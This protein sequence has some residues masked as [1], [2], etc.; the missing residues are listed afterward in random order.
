MNCLRTKITFVI[1]AM[2]LGRDGK[3]LFERL[4][5]GDGL[6]CLDAGCGGGVTLETQR[7]NHYVSTNGR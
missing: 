3:R 5:I 1:L 4:G 2:I 7:K 6:K